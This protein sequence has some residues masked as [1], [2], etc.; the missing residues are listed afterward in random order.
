[1]IRS[2]LRELSTSEDLPEGADLD[3]LTVI[4]LTG[5]RTDPELIFL[6]QQNGL[7]AIFPINPVITALVIFQGGG[8]VSFS[9]SMWKGSKNQRHYSGDAASIE[10]FVEMARNFITSCA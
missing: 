3:L 5:F 4:A 1:M 10:C 6:D 2:R 9:I 8:R 7:V